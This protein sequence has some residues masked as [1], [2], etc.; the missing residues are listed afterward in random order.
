S[1]I[2]SQLDFYPTMANIMGYKIEKGLIFGRD[3]NNYEGNNQVNPIMFMERGSFL[4]D[5]I[6]FEL[7]RDQIYEHSIAKNIKT[8]QEL[9]I[10]NLRPLTIKA[11]GEILKSNY[12]LKKNI[13]KN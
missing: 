1:R 8:G 11:K 10:E 12:I 7:S 13:L 9:D 2:G 5:D 6:F 4:N 3:L